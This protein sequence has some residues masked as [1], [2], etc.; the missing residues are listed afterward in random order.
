LP[1]NQIEITRKQMIK[2]FNRD[3]RNKRKENTK[4]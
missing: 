4:H 2:L 3:S 1:L